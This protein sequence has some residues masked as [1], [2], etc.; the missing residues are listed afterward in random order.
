[1]ENV[2]ESR[3]SYLYGYSR[4]VYPVFFHRKYEHSNVDTVLF[5]M[6]TIYDHN[7]YSWF[8]PGSDP[9][10]EL[11]DSMGWDWAQYLNTNSKI[12]AKQCLCCAAGDL[13]NIIKM[14]KIIHFPKKIPPNLK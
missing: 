2:I 3:D 10:S 14:V 1:M 4:F 6:F 12:T 11:N 8:Y 7:I 5:S 13:Y 9:H